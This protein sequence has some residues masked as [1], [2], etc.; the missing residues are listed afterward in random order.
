MFENLNRPMVITALAFET[1]RAKRIV[2]TRVL[3]GG[4]SCNNFS[5]EIGP[6]PR[7]AEIMAPSIFEA[8]NKSSWNSRVPVLAYDCIPTI[9]NRCDF[10]HDRV[11][12]SYDFPGI[13]SI[14]VINQRC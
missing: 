12:P 11:Y 2:R 10:K 3:Y 9:Q 7:R 14:H 8:K 5:M 13:P 1:N 4:F 6:S